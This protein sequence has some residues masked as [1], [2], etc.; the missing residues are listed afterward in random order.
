M[1]WVEQ[2]LMLGPFHV[3]VKTNPSWMDASLEEG[4]MGLK[5]IDCV[6]SIRHKCPMYFFPFMIAAHLEAMRFDVS[7][8]AI[9]WFLQHFGGQCFFMYLCNMHEPTLHLEFLSNYTADLSLLEYNLLSYLPSLHRLFSYKLTWNSTLAHYTQYKPSTLSDCILVW[10]TSI[11]RW[12]ILIYVAKL[13]NDEFYIGLWQKHATGE[14]QH[15]TFAM[16][17]Q[18]TLYPRIF[19]KIFYISL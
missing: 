16:A 7:L 2:N 5:A 11:I 19:S 15:Y 12:R 3:G 8:V 9:E 4:A 13:L 14:I 6:L 10:Y 17:D 18:F 1:S